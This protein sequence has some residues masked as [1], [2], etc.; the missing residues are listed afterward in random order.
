MSNINNSVT[1]LVGETGLTYTMEL[2][3]FV[4]G[5]AV[6]P[7]L[8]LGVSV[9][10]TDA[11]GYTQDYE[12]GF[13][14]HADNVLSGNVELSLLGGVVAENATVTVLTAGVFGCEWRRLLYH[15]NGCAMV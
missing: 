11:A 7:S 10:H 13:F 4:I 2:S 12:S 3:D 8:V 15:M 9:V 1:V 14:S 6:N 5:D